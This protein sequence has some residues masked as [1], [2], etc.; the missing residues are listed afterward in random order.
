M[1]GKYSKSFNQT[2]VKNLRK[3]YNLSNSEKRNILSAATLVL[4]SAA[5]RTKRK[6]H[7]Q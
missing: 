1:N 7:K 3:H 5:K 4:S 2:T 6:K